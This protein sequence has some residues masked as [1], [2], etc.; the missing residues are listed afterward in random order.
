MATQQNTSKIIRSVS[1]S[2]YNFTPISNN[3]IRNTNISLEAIGLVSFIISLPED[4]VIYKGQVQRALKMGDLKFDRIWKECVGAGY[5]SVKKQRLSNGRW[6]YDYT[7]TDNVSVSENTTGGKVRG[8]KPTSIIKKEKEKKDKENN[9]QENNNS[10]PGNS[11]SL[12][13]DIFNSNTSTED[14]LNYINNK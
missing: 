12:F 4:W 6:K 14:I 8:G 3:L 13:A 1:S 11:V 9:I 5:I 10:I 2:K 7:I